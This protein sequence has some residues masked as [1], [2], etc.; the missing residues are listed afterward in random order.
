MRISEQL[1]VM[2]RFEIYSTDRSYSAQLVSR[3][4]ADV[5]TVVH[6]LNLKEA[7]VDRNGLYCFSVRLD[8]AGFWIIFHYAQ[9]GHAEAR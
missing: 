1:I 7:E 6:H 9:R 5:L 2:A 8:D 3:D 4:A